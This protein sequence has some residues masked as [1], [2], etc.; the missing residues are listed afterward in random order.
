MIKTKDGD[1]LIHKKTWDTISQDEHFK[2][3]AEE[4]EDLEAHYESMQDKE[5]VSFDEYLKNRKS[6]V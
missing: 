2:E 5:N 3:L 6:N 4:I 1:I